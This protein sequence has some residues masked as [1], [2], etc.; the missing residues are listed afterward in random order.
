LGTESTLIKVAIF[1]REP[2]TSQ[3]LPRWRTN[4]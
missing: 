1:G 2:S 3:Y 4:G